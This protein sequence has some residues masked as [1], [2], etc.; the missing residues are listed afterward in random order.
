MTT[1]RSGIGHLVAL[2]AAFVLVACQQG[3]PGPAATST[4]SP[5]HDAGAGHTAAPPTVGPGD[6]EVGTV[7]EFSID[8]P[9][10]Q[11]AGQPPVSPTHHDGSTHEITFDVLGDQTL[12]VTGQNDDAVVEIALDG[13]KTFHEMPAGSGPHGIEFNAASRLWLT[14]E[15]Q[16]KIVRLDGDGDIVET[17]DVRLECGTCAAPLNPHPHG[18]AIDPD[19][20]TVWYTGKSTDTLGRVNP[21]GTID[22]FPLETVGS[23]PIYIRA[24]PD[25]NMW[26]TELVGNAIGRITP[27][28]EV[29][30]FPISTANSRPIA[31]VPD[32]EGPYMW[33]TEEAGNKVGRIDMD[34]NI[35]EFPVPKTQDN[36]ILAGLAFDSD[37]NLWLQQYVDPARPFPAGPD[38][39]VRIDKTILA[40]DGPDSSRAP[41]TYYQVPTSDTVMH[42]VIQGPDG[43]MWFTEL[44][45]DRVGRVTTGLAP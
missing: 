8:Y 7:K 44:A 40:A 28:G 42:R 10:Q 14:L 33:F 17:F 27:A 23:V 30:E 37:G 13:S 43:N 20:E 38:H 32:P 34:G 35:I 22:T 41:F 18:L 6:G 45:A 2:M 21:D 36:V 29:K 12:W 9:G 39:I 24:G 4:T 15:F 19:G 25:G 16:G 3:S 26:F 1:R 11:P 31:I 5:D